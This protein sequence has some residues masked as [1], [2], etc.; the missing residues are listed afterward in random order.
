MGDN[1]VCSC[2]DDWQATNKWQPQPK[3]EPEPWKP[4]WNYNQG[5]NYRPKPSKP[6]RPGGIYNVPKDQR[7]ARNPNKLNKPQKYKPASGGKPPR[8]KK[9]K[10]PKNNVSINL[11]GI[12]LLS[13]L[14][15][16]SNVCLTTH[17]FSYRND[18]RKRRRSNRR[19]RRKRIRNRIAKETQRIGPRQNRRLVLRRRMVGRRS[20]V[21]LPNE[22]LIKNVHKES[23]VCI[24]SFKCSSISVIPY[25]ELSLQVY[26]YTVLCNK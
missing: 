21:S 7:P 14:S 17:I 20:V 25:I 12:V 10:P 4:Q 2:A 15:R 3:P 9:Q 24:N 18:R 8:N 5:Q 13:S 19:Y 23:F 22:Y 11:I 6:A 26:T 1:C 16:A